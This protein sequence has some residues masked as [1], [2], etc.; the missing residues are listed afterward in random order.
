MFTISHFAPPLLKTTFVYET[1]LESIKTRFSHYKR[2]AITI[3]IAPMFSR[4][5]PVPCGFDTFAKIRF[6]GFDKKQ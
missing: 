5:S 1:W 3:T 2:A 6:G 4:F